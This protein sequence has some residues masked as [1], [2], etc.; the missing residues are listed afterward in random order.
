MI[1]A[2]E[3]TNAADLI[4]AASQTR[5]RMWGKVAK[6]KMLAPP[7]SEIIIVDP[8]QQDHHVKAYRIHKARVLLGYEPP[9]MPSIALHKPQRPEVDIQELQT[10][11]VFQDETQAGNPPRKS[12][13]QI[14]MEV[15]RFFPKVSFDE[16]VGS[17]RTKSLIYPRHLCMYEI[18][19]Q[20]HDLPTTTI[21]KFFGRDHTTLLYAVHKIAVMAEGGE[22]FALWTE[23]K[24]QKAAAVKAAYRDKKTPM[25]YGDLQVSSNA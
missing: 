10:A 23:N 25:M 8:P 3:Y 14:V 7:V 11:I 16:V 21:A 9:V 12:M 1:Q 19:N 15:L 20:R 2:I 22:K 5:Q 4:R 13:K 24:G 17:R 6:P 18:Y